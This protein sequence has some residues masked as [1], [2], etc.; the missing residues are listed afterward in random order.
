MDAKQDAKLLSLVER[1]TCA[2]EN[3]ARMLDDFL[4]DLVNYSE[5]YNGKRCMDCGVKLESPF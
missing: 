4:R 2:M 5:E 3:I 1:Q